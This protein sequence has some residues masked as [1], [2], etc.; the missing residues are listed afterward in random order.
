MQSK[1]FKLLEFFV[2]F[3]VLPVSFVLEYAFVLKLI[4]GVLGFLYIIYYILR[5][6]KLKMS[7]SNSIYW[8]KFWRETLFKFLGISVI[9]GVYMFFFDS[10]KLFS[11][12]IN[13]PFLWGAILFI[14]SV[15]S[16]YP[17]EVIYRTFFFNRYHS[18]FQSKALL[19]VVNALLFSLA[20]LFFGNAL[21]LF[22]TFVGGFLFAYTYSKTQSTLL[23][24]IEHA[25]FG[26]WLFTVGMGEMLGFPV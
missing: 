10:T 19:I 16:V 25:I 24:S 15:F 14:Y 9:T 21:A 12:V 20:H 11:V 8:K 3:I 6:E 17:Q 23:V 18:L 7:I 26:S 22:L 1:P 4:F 2:L 5:I 13:K